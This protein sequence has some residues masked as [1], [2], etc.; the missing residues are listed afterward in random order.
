[1][2]EQKK[3]ISIITDK[4]FAEKHDPPF[5][6]PSFLSFETPLRIKSILAYFE[7]INL[8]SD[9]RL[10]KGTPI[11]IGEEVIQLAH[12]SYLINSIKNLSNYGSGFLGDEVFI[13]PHTFKVAKKAVGGAIRAVED[14]YTGKAN[15]SFALIRP[16]GHH[17]IHQKSSGLC[18]FNNIALSIL[19]L[20]DKLNI[21]DKIAIVDIDDHFGDGLSQYFYEDPNVLY[22][23]VHEFDFMEGGIGFINE[24]G[25]GE[26]AG[27]NINYPIPNG[28]YDKIFLSLFDVLDPLLTQFDPKLIIVACGFDMYFEDPIGNCRLTTKAYYEFART[29]S[30]LAEK[31]CQGKIAFILEG[32]YS[33]IGLP[34]CVHSMI[35]ALLGKPYVRPKFENIDFSNPNIEDEVRRI[36]EAVFRVLGEYWNFS[37][38]EDQKANINPE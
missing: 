33:I 18:I 15:H 21:T 13:T 24:V 6:N 12:S 36:K 10:V 35:N 34:Y 22:F 7:R 25:E 27:K 14:V 32:G 5:V 26:G 17:A 31:V 16:P 19:Y 20:R 38:E 11:E 28:A 9:K 3:L 1:M 29:L 2:S 4:D 37:R 8:F 23:S 30:T